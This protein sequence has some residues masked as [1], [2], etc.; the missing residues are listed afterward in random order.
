MTRTE[1]FEQRRQAMSDAALIGFASDYISELAKTG[2][3]S[4]RM[5]I[6]PEITDTD[7]ILSEVVRRFKKTTE[8]TFDIN[9]HGTPT[10]GEIWERASST[11]VVE[12]IDW[13]NRE[14]IRFHKTM[15]ENLI[16]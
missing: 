3:R 8:R 4:H 7:M 11:N 1:A 10:L 13:C 16:P 14:R 2:G 6:P 5:C 12:F 15:P 9:V